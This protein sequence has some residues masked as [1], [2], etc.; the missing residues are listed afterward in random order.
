MIRQNLTFLYPLMEGGREGGRE[1]GREGGREGSFSSV[2]IYCASIDRLSRIDH[3][4]QT[5]NMNQHRSCIYVHC[6]FSNVFV[7]AKISVMKPPSHTYDP[8]STGNIEY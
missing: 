4:R 5:K 6:C 3:S 7:I 2:R 1:E 8:R